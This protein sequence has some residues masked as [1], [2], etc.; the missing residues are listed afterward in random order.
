VTPREAAAARHTSIVG[1]FH[2]HDFGVKQ[3]VDTAAKEVGL[4]R[5]RHRQPA[6]PCYTSPRSAVLDKPE[7]GGLFS[8]A[9][10]RLDKPEEG[11]LFST[12]HL[13]LDKPEEGGLFSTAHLGH[14]R[15]SKACS[16]CKQG[17]GVGKR[18]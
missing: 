15:Q 13:R 8:T 2:V 3:D 10:L 18:C 4:L 16:S 7:E 14:W 11:G 6:P 17:T 12:A 9:H 1:L 5:T